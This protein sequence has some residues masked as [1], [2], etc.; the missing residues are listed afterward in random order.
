MDAV[1]LNYNSSSK[2]DLLP[3]SK[4]LMHAFFL[5]TK[6]THMVSCIQAVNR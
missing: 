4:A 5:R 3:A 1:V 6:E 2:I